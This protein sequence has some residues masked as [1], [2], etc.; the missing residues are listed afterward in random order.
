MKLGDEVLPQLEAL[1]ACQITGG[2]G[3]GLEE[4]LPVPKWQFLCWL[5]DHKNVLLHGSGDPNITEFEPRQSNDLAEF[6][7]RK[8]VYAAGD[9]IWPMFFA[10]V[11][12]VRYRMTIV[13]AAIRLETPDGTISDPYY[14]F[15]LTD[16][17]FVQKPWREGFVYVLPKTGFEE[18]P[19]DVI[20]DVRVH[21]HHW[22]SLRAVRPL[23]KLR[24]RP[25]DFPFLEQ[26][27]PQNDERLAERTRANPDGFPWVE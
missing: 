20:G 26:I 21:T 19:G 14:Y 2:G 23:A 18:Q 10:I 25:E 15:A 7:N 17:V 12:R 8:A 1:Y 3:N 16:S 13:N 24:V 27:R 11:D 5:A 9:G 6:G 22:A 4:P